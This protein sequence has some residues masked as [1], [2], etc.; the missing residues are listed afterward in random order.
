[1]KKRLFLLLAAL[2]IVLTGCSSNPAEKG[3]TGALN[4]SEPLGNS[5][6]DESLKM[7]EAL[8]ADR[9]I[10]T[11]FITENGETY[12]FEGEYTGELKDDKPHGYGEFLFTGDGETGFRYQGEFA[13][14]TFHGNGKLRFTGTDDPYEMEGRFTDGAFTPTTGQT[15]NFIGQLGIFGRFSVPEDVM[16]YI[17]S[18]D[19][20]FPVCEIEAID[21]AEL[22]HFSNK[23]FKKLRK[24]EEIGLVRLSLHTQQVF[25]D[26]LFD[27]KLT[28]V[29]AYDD[30]G[31]FY[32]V[33][34]LDSVDAYEGDDITVYAVPCATS[35]FDNIG[36]GTTLVTVL[37]CCS[38][39][40]A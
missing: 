31:E 20:L 15:C 5:A 1:M 39:S 38:M 36:G 2:L 26:D 6:A 28:S 29:L 18:H 30:G 12:E 23:Q 19:K 32:A 33:Y 9:K 24:Q 34:Y 7:P 27:G 21:D 13:D 37:L 11:V 10:V 17:D 22:N 8:R 40:I 25:E 3:Q 16:H 35:S 14:G 4:D